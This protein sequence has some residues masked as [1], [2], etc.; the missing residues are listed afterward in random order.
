V[1]LSTKAHFAVLCTNLFFAANYSL[2]KLVSPA[3]V[4][5]FALNGLRVGICSLLL[6]GLW[7][8]GKTGAG[9]EKRDVGRFVLCG[10]AGVSINQMLF[11]K[12]LTMTSTVHA[13]LLMLTT[14]LLITIFAFFVLKETVS[15]KKI[16][17]LVFGIGG[18]LLIIL[19]KETKAADNSLGG[20]VLILINATSYSVY[21]ILVQ[22]LMKRYSPL[23]VIRWVFTIGFFIILPF[24]FGELSSL[25]YTA[26]GTEQLLI[27]SLI[28][29]TGT[30]L[31]YLFNAY[32]LQHL[33]AGITGAYIYTQPVF[34]FIIA[35]FLLGESLSVE[36]ILAAVLIFSGVYLV[37]FKKRAE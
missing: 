15:A 14:P 2:V 10:L 11:I 22:P 19:S 36:K 7:L 9:I 13:S 24:A 8:F 29:F 6:W 12:G 27:L 32:G 17:G 31:A 30:F 3:F 20:D 23:H 4:K 18:A 28:I 1:K 16:L 33:G 21:F 37:S 35:A 26:L 34:A 25:H 5:P